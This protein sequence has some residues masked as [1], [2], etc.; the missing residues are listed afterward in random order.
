VS[1]IDVLRLDH[2]SY[3][4][5]DLDRSVAFY[6]RLGFERVNRYQESGPQTDRGAATENADMDIQ[7]LRHRS[8][9][10]M[11]ELIRYLRHPAERAVRNSVVGSAHLAFVVAD[12]DAA[13]AKLSNDGVEF[14]ST[15]NVDQYG[16]K[17]VYL[18]DPDGIPA[19]LM[20]PGP[21][22]QRAHDAAGE[23]N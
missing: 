10:Q 21:P 17:W 23:E 11:L 1:A 9:G 2:F 5:G 7:L 15:P 13:Y 19:E 8:G 4:V 14:L 6:E 3:T 16:E 22:S 12:M 18:R 20:Q